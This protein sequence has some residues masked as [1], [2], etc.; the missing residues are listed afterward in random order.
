[1][2]AKSN[3]IQSFRYMPLVSVQLLKQTKRTIAGP[4]VRA[5]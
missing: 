3:A 2:V 4:S 1:V 5:V